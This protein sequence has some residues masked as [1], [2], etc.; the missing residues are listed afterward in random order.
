MLAVEAGPGGAASTFTQLEVP[1]GVLQ[2]RFL[3]QKRSD[4]VDIVNN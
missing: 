4:I 1:N 3:K 2:Y